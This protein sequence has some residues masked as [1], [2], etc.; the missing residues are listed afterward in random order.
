MK[1]KSVELYIAAFFFFLPIG[2]AQMGAE[3]LQSST[4]NGAQR[5]IALLV[6]I[7][8]YTHVQSL[9]GCVNDVNE[10]RS[11]LISSFH[12]DSKDILVLTNNKAKRRDIIDAITTHLIGQARAGDIVFFHFSGHGS[13][14]ADSSD[15]FGYDNT[16]VPC[17][18]R[19]PKGLVK[20]ITDKELN[21]LFSQLAQKTTNITVVLDSCHSGTGLKT[22]S[23]HIRSIPRDERFAG[24]AAPSGSQRSSPQ[25]SVENGS[26]YGNSDLDY[27]LIAGCRTDQLS[28]ELEDHKQIYGALTHYLI[29]EL[30]R[31][32]NQTGLTYREIMPRVVT[33]VHSDFPFQT[34]QLEG[35]GRDRV[36]FSEN[37]RP[38]DRS[39]RVSSSRGNE[40]TLEG[41][42]LHGFTVG[43]IFKLVDPQIFG[44]NVI[45]RAALISVEGLKSTGRMIE[46]T[47]VP[48]DARAVEE[49][50]NYESMKTKVSFEP[51]SSK[52][53]KDLRGELKKANDVFELT[54]T[55]QAQ[56][57]FK[58]TNG[59]VRIYSSDGR[60]LG[61]E[62][63]AG[64]PNAL[65]L[66][67][68]RARVWGRWFGVNRIQ[69][70][71]STLRVEFALSPTVANARSAAGGFTFSPG[72]N[73]FDIK[74]KNSSVDKV[75]IYI[76]QLSNDGTVS[77][78]YPQDGSTTPLDIGETISI[79]G[80]NVALPPSSQ[81]CGWDI[82]KLIAAKDQVDLS[83]L[84][85]SAA[86]G[87]RGEEPKDPLSQLLFD[88]ATGF[89]VTSRTV[90]NAWVT[91]DLYYDICVGRSPDG[92]CACGE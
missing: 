73:L 14:M 83:V 84:E 82:L 36:V 70:L 21:G 41:G 40:V 42:S 47:S 12:F 31:P 75:L 54:T 23:S 29:R 35:K 72:T 30:L 16:I 27:A 24:K 80:W 61:P 87:E 63:S 90:P 74:V 26:G 67:V 22:A 79:P 50:H 2:C 48:V 33:A 52:L 19:D 11:A 25:R 15:P 85:Q 4:W 55:E 28:Q 39:V 58:E 91:A 8:K 62:L 46:G 34:P 43:S 76:L 60:I 71:S 45:G 20:D 32:G 69:N 53:L 9:G 49:K 51:E 18:S 5:R 59:V 56:L 1:P 64:A 78:I 88:A 17:D 6:G 89:R 10:M 92:G 57:R 13:T 65:T 66:L 68:G 81:K 7:N 37:N 38:T 3:V 77:Q 86:K 44:T